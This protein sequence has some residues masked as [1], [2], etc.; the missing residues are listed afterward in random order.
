MADPT[1]I[2]SGADDTKYAF[3]VYDPNPPWNDVPGC[4][5]FAK[6]GPTGWQALYI[7][8]TNSFQRRLT[9]AHEKWQAAVQM[10]MTHIHAHTG[11]PEETVRLQEERNLVGRYRPPLN[12]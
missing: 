11:N 9:P 10:G 12:S 1:V 5:I 2:W 8:Q 3:K 7:G 4:Y 6:Q